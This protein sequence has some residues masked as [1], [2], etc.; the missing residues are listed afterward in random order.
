MP[1]ETDPISEL[2][3]LEEAEEAPETEEQEEIDE[4]EEEEQQ[5]PDRQYAGK[6]RSPE[7][8]E[9]SYIQLQ[10]RLG[11]MGNELGQLRQL[12][13][14]AQ[15]PQQQQQDQG[16][17][18]EEWQEWAL[19]SPFEAHQYLAQSVMEQRLAQVMQAQQQQLAP[20]FETVNQQAASHALDTLKAEF[21]DDVVKRNREAL[22]ERLTKDE[23]YFIDPGTRLERLREALAAAEWRRGREAQSSRPRR[24]NGRYAPRAAHVEGGST[25]QPSEATDE[26]DPIVREMDEAAPIRDA[27]GSVPRPPA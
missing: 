16:M 7:E 5:E 11:E 13:S 18:V 17:T 15:Q 8:L 24:E 20:V 21:G 14:Q 12:V 26:R 25:P 27:F 2:Q 6:F 3:A 23:G 19:E 4:A 9:Q 1:P 22:A 10:S